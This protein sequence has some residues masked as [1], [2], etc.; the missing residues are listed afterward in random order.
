MCREHLKNCFKTIGAPHQTTV[1]V[2]GDDADA[3]NQVFVALDGAEKISWNSGFG[4][5]N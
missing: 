5:F 3:K 4:L 2:A 1:L